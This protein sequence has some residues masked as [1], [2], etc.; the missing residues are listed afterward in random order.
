MRERWNQA[1]SISRRRSSRRISGGRAAATAS[2]SSTSWVASLS[3][4]TTP[5][6]TWPS[7]PVMS[8]D[9]DSSRARNASASARPRRDR[10]SYS[11]AGP[12]S[13]TQGLLASPGAGGGHGGLQVAGNAVAQETASQRPPEPFRGDQQQIGRLLMRFLGTGRA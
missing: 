10:A 1:G 4:S 7:G 11:T 3:T 2:A 12:S 5:P 6:Y 8:K 13:G 9:S